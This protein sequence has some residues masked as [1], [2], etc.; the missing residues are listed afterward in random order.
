MSGRSSGEGSLWLVCVVLLD[1]LGRD[2]LKVTAAEDGTVSGLSRRM[3]P[4]TR[5]QLALARGADGG[6]DGSAV[7]AAKTA[8]KEVEGDGERG[9]SRSR[10][11]NWTVRASPAISI[12]RLRACSGPSWRRRSR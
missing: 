5:A 12:T 7:H 9:V 2:C 11:E 10:S 4:V 8:S 6:G 3:V 1:V